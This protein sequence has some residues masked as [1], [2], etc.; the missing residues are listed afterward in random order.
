VNYFN[1]SIEQHMK[2]GARNAPTAEAIDW[3]GITAELDKEG[4]AIVPYLLDGA[5]CDEIASL[6]TEESG[7]GRRVTLQSRDLGRGDTWQLRG[8]AAESLLEWRA[9]L[10]ERLVPI[11][12][13]WIATMNSNADHE[14][15]GQPRN[16]VRRDAAEI[17]LQAEVSVLPTEG[18]QALHQSTEETW[19]FPLQLVVLLS[20][21]EVD[22]TGGQ[23]VMTEQRPR[24]QSRPMVLPLRKGS[25]ALITVANRPFRGS[26]GF[27]RVSMKHAISRV[28]SG[29]RVGLEV[30]FHGSN[31]DL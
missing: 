17:P 28:R 15:A 4:Y 10:Y 25:V 2:I 13:R 7:S 14:L 31:G 24:M 1:A 6:A 27:Y 29:R 11:A 12:S 30:L 5:L 3:S 22:F 16:G 21:P 20:E 9:S 26:K 19:N 23:F 18:F 8:P